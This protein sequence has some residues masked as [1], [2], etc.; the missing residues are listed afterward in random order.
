MYFVLKQIIVSWD[1]KEAM[2]YR[3]I[4]ASLHARAILTFIENSIA[5]NFNSAHFEMQ[6][7]TNIVY[8]S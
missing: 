1:K 3:K 7:T 4:I 8:W 2:H 6:Q 5:S